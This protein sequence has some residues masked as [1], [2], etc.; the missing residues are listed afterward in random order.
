MESFDSMLDKVYE[1]LEEKKN[2]FKIILPEPQLIKS[3]HKTIWKNI[4]DYLKIINR[5]PYHFINYINKETT[6][7]AFWITDN[8]ADGCIFSNKTTKDY[9]YELMKKYIKEQII[10]KSC[11]NI[12]TNIEKN[13]ELRKYKL[14]CNNCKSEYI[15]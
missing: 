11:Q 3:G 12:D 13:K 8:I 10:C 14:Y 5:E 9:I 2:N 4:K 1:N 15:L 7:T 6:T